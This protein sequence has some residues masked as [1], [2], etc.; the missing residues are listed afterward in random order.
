MKIED[1]P[2]TVRVGAFTYDICEMTQEIREK[3]FPEDSDEERHN[4]N[5]IKTL[6]GRCDSLACKIY[7]HLDSHQPDIN[8]VNTLLHEIMHAIVY[9]AGFREAEHAPSEEQAVSMM[10]NG[11]MQ[12]MLDNPHVWHWITKQVCPTI[13]GLDLA[14]DVII[15]ND[16]LPGGVSSISVPPGVVGVGGVGNPGTTSVQYV[17][18]AGGAGSGGSGRGQ[19]RRFN[20]PDDD[21]A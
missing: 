8:I 12:V 3:G 11:L 15:E 18:G 4:P 13:F 19:H 17:R 14:K 1:L 5:R 2:R 21:D 20:P 7:I 10:T 9:H 6:V 16:Q